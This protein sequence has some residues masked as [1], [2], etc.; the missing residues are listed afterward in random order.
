MWGGGV[1]TGVGEEMSKY[2]NTPVPSSSAVERFFSE[3]RI[4]FVDDNS[5]LSAIWSVHSEFL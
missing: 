2:K 5:G 3:P 4:V 1:R